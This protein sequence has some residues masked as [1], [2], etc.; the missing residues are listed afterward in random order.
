M[1]TQNTTGIVLVDD[2]QETLEFLS[3][4]FEENGFKPHSFLRAK[5]ALNFLKTT[6]EKIYL[7]LCD[8]KMPEIDGL[9][10]HNKVR[11]LPA[12]TD[13]PFLFLT[14]VN[15][16]DIRLKA[17]KQGAIG[18]ISKP[19]DNEILLA[20]IRAML[21][22]YARVRISNGTILKGDQGKLTVEEIITYC[23]A[24]KVDGYVLF[25]NKKDPG[26]ML[27]KKGVLGTIRCG[28]KKDADA[29]EQ[30]TGWKNYWF[31]IIR[32]TFD[33]VLIRYYFSS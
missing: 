11:S 12:F 30:L 28:K 9:Q 4:L 18:F 16:R 23:E 26:I 1:E 10:F 20:K 3:S 8:V 21:H 15:D 2:E 17:F 24:E 33:P 13:T 32:G 27:F 14:A 22:F 6:N 19:I 7:I 25:Y 29:F 5:E 31:Y